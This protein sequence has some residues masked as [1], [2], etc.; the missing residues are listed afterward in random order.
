MRVKVVTVIRAEL[1]LCVTSLFLGLTELLR[2]VR[3]S[4]RTNQLRLGQF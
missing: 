2:R 3:P 1:A 4:V